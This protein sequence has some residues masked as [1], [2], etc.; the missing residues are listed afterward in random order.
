MSKRTTEDGRS[1][2]NVVVKAGNG[3]S[4]VDM[5]SW[6]ADKAAETVANG[7]VRE[8]LS[9]YRKLLQ[10]GRNDQQ[11]V[12]RT[13]LRMAELLL[14]LGDTPRA[15]T[16]LLEV[17]TASPASAYGHYLLGRLYT[18]SHQWDMAVEHATTACHLEPGISEY[19]QSLG[20]ALLCSGVWREGCE[21]LEQALELD[22]DNTAA[23][24]D[25]AMADAQQGRHERAEESLRRAISRHRG[26][27]MLSET[28]AAVIRIRREN[29]S[30][31]DEPTDAG[32]DVDRGETISRFSQQV[33]EMLADSLGSK[34]Y[35][36]GVIDGAMRLCLDFEHRCGVGQSNPIVMA[37]ACEYTISQLM[38]MRGVTQTRVAGDYG[39][40][41]AGISVK[42]RAMM[43]RLNLVYGDPRYLPE[44]VM[45]ETDGS[46]E[47]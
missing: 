39:I 47:W 10:V 16:H 6:I 26:D 29:R 25:L 15:E 19:H 27:A 22:P 34:N 17:V 7:T 44:W 32:V 36:P 23:I 28:L 9:W 42:Y 11:L 30:R 12:T 46:P 2:G 41:T 20:R 31:S 40:S 24:C 4:Y 21:S 33:C 14:Q 3:G 45:E 38:G 8:A 1:R 18:E 35:P 43:R 5:V 37:A 13:H